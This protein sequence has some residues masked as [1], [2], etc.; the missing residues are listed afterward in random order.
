MRLSWF[1]R[2]GLM[3]GA[4]VAVVFSAAP[5]KA[6]AQSGFPFGSELRM[7]ARPLKGSKRVPYV[8]IDANGSALIDMWCDSVR[9]QFVIA[10]DTVTVL[11][12]QKTQRSCTPEQ[13]RADGELLDALQQA[14]NWKR[15][16]DGVI[17][18]GA[19]QLR[20]RPST[21]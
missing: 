16:G 14:T 11:I 9:S 15:D 6:Q 19:R 10:A 20:F 3:A 8:E 2:R 1:V 7:D 4:A 12:G 18:I 17:L 5:A 21:N 13:A